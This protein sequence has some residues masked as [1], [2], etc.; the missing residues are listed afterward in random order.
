[1]DTHTAEG[2]CS[3]DFDRKAHISFDALKEALQTEAHVGSF[4]SA[5][6]KTV[7]HERR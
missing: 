6:W 7:V 2:Y 4:P 3:F 1:M 5:R